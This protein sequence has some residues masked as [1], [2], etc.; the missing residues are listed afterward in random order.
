VAGTAALRELKAEPATVFAFAEPDDDAELRALLRRSVIPGAIRVAFTREPDYFDGEGLAGNDDVTLVARRGG[1]IVGMGRCSIN[2]LVRNGVPRRIG[3]LGELRVD[4][5]TPAT[6]RMLRDGYEFLSR[7]VS[8]DGFFTS[9]SSDNDRA[10]RAL[11]RGARFGLPTYQKLCDLVTLVAPVT[12]SAARVGTNAPDADELRE[13]LAAESRRG[14]LSLSW[15]AEQWCALAEHD[16]TPASFVTARLGTRLVGAAAIW[17]QRR[18]RQT[19]IDGYSTGVALAR[20]LLNGIQSLRAGARLPAPGAILA[21]GALLGAVVDTPDVWPKLWPAL[22]SRAAGMGLDWLTV[23][24]DARDDDIPVLRRL[25]RAR[26][27]YT[28]LYSVT[29]RDGA[30]WQDLWDARCFRPEVALL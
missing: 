19:V 15:N 1:G 5:G 25:L 27:Y 22:E 9:I 10:R 8:A 29:W 21:Q 3:Y 2:T 26:E 6:P 4:P 20:P 12:P 11:E 16:I 30:R 13:Y 7:Y 24:R 17:D 23:A 14:H 18:F 28:S